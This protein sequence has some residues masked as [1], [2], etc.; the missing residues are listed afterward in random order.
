MPKPHSC[1]PV[2][3][4]A[5]TT[6][7]Q[8]RPVRGFV[9]SSLDF[10]KENRRMKLRTLI[11]LFRSGQLSLLRSLTKEVR[12]YHRLAFL[13]SG[14]SSGLLNRLAAGPVPLEGLESEFVADP[15]MR[16]GFEAWLGL[17]LALG[18]LRSTSEGY[19]LRGKLSRRLV[20]PRN[21]AA[22]ASIEEVVTLHNRLINESPERLRQG[23]PFSLADQDAR[24]IARSSRLHE[25]FICEAI[26]EAIPKHGQVA[27]LEIGCGAAAY[28][29]YAAERNP[30][31]TALGLELQPA[32]APLAAENIAQW[33]LS[34]RV[35]VEV[36]DVMQ[37]ASQPVFDIATLHQNIY[38]FP[39]AARTGVLRHVLS[40]LKPGGRLLVTTVCQGPGAAVDVLN[41]WGAMTEGCGRLP[42]PEELIGQFQ[43]AGYTNVKLKRLVPGDSFY[44]FLGQ[45]SEGS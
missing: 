40:F 15:A 19:T 8:T 32:A 16:D 45:R 14:L 27:L 42:S 10:A 26:D 41:I 29:R 17:G 21:D 9:D 37:R 24:L 7:P 43:Q 44:S 4:E 35:S 3:E 33:G 13:A 12:R 23:R 2:C 18:E 36:G 31:L 34:D 30:E 38:Y 5:R 11:R 20:D 6:Q 1:S 28:I 39:L 25:P 22:A